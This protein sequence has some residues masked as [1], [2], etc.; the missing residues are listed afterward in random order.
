MASASL[1]S[2]QLL[3]GWLSDSAIVSAVAR[4]LGQTAT[5]ATPP[6][7][8]EPV[9][10]IGLVSMGAL[11]RLTPISRSWGYERGGPIDRYYIEGFL[12]EHQHDVRGHVLEIQN[13]R[14]TRL[15]GGDRVTK[16]D[17][18]D[19]NPANRRATII[20]DLTAAD[21]LASETFDC[22]IFTQTLHA[23]DDP[24]PVVETLYRILKPGGILLATLPGISQVREQDW[25]GYWSGGHRSARVMF[26]RVFGASAVEIR[27][28]GNVLAAIAFLQGLGALE[29]RRDEL[30]YHDPAYEVSIAI[31]AVKSSSDTAP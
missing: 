3:A 24:R 9:P 17:V 16:S 19:M 4:W 6:R 21:A 25:G 12:A 14:Y 28:Y 29:L 30:D 5:A 27:T 11:R 10:G 26:A 8:A 13:D 2:G 7:T 31:R 1:R 22:I 23:I 18:L 20:A 15:F